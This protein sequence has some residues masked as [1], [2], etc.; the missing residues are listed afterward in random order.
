MTAGQQPCV[1]LRSGARPLPERDKEREKYTE[2]G[3][4]RESLSVGAGT[5]HMRCPPS[6]REGASSQGSV[7]R[8][9]RA[10]S[11]RGRGR[12]KGGAKVASASR[13]PE[14]ESQSP[15]DLNAPRNLARRPRNLAL[16]LLTGNRKLGASSAGRIATVRCRAREES[17]DRINPPAV[18][19]ACR[20][21]KNGGEREREGGRRIVSFRSFFH[22]SK[23][24]GA[25]RVNP[26]RSCSTL[27][28]VSVILVCLR[29]F[30][31]SLGDEF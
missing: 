9:G 24:K 17:A 14:R 20:A 10:R 22:K 11:K 4:G 8:G 18:S 28:H 13:R 26:I 6:T 5:K 1:R 3:G 25:N 30:V 29:L 15:A 2:R 21:R 31:S 12:R 23:N 7:C 16:L 27:C 19:L